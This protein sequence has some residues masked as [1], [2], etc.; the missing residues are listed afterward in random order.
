[1]IFIIFWIFY[2]IYWNRIFFHWDV[3]LRH[4]RVPKSNSPI[5]CMYNFVLP[6][7]DIHY[8]FDKNKYVRFPCHTFIPSILIRPNVNLE[9]PPYDNY[10]HCTF[11][12]IWCPML[13][14]LHWKQE[15]L[16]E[17][18]NL[19]TDWNYLL[20]HPCKGSWR[21]ACTWTCFQRFVQTSLPTSQLE[22]VIKI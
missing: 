8:L 16:M 21:G 20:R 1:M 10:A 5:Y 4:S 19:H 3:W 2:Y 22:F 9:P 6:L 17:N 13:T 11:K 7:Q 18:Q 12:Y 15:V 14:R